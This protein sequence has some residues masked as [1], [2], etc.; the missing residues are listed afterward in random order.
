MMRLST[1]GLLF[2]ASIAVAQTPTIPVNPPA[3]IPTPAPSAAINF[4]SGKGPYY[5]G[6]PIKVTVTTAGDTVV[7]VGDFD[8]IEPRKETDGKLVYFVPL[9]AKTYTLQAYTA[10]GNKPTPIHT[11]SI[12]V[13][14]DPK[15]K[16]APK[17]VPPL[18]VNPSP[19]P[20]APPVD[21]TP[22]PVPPAPKTISFPLFL[23]VI[24]DVNATDP[25]SKNLNAM[26]AN[27]EFRTYLAAN[28]VK[29]KMLDYKIDADE[30]AS[31]KFDT[32]FLAPLGNKI[33]CYGIIDST[34]ALVAKGLLPASSAD[35]ESVIAKLIQK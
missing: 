15:K 12:K 32:A 20:P 5:V 13:V 25:N 8:L 18:P 33:P 7:W 30:I 10:I 27:N 3:P 2:L 11:L 35:M 6:K 34:G 26:A 22:A 23:E 24:H 4:D 21:P 17:P 14:D 31:K 28:R 16:P 1:I 9:E 29:W 19:K